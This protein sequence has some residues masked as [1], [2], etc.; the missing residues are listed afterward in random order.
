MVAS[1]MKIKDAAKEVAGKN[2]KISQII[3]QYYRS[4][5]G[6][7]RVHGNTT[8]TID[9]E[10]QLIGLIQAIDAYDKPLNEMQVIQLAK[11]VFPGRLNSDGRRWFKRFMKSWKREVSHKSTKGLGDKR[12]DIHVLN[13][14]KRWVKFFPDWCDSLGI[15]VNCLLNLDETLLRIDISFCT[16]KGSLTLQSTNRP[17]SILKGLKLAPICLL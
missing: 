15:K 17:L 3:G 2:G 12:V 1:G 13:D 9:E 8:L 6:T 5:R 4:L 16:T 7:G 14:V 10:R 11:K